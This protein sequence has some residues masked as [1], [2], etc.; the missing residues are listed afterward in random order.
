MRRT[1]VVATVV[2]LAASAA[3]LGFFWPFGERQSVLRLAGIVE[4]QEVR[5][6]SKVGGRVQEVLVVEGQIVSP[7]TSLVVFD[8]PE[9]EA[10]RDQL[11]AKLDAAVADWE[12]AKNGPRKEEI[13]AAQAAAEA[14]KARYERMLAGWR[15]E[16]K[17]QAKADL[18]SAEAEF[19][20]ALEDYERARELYRQRSTSRAEYDAAL[21]TR[22]RTR[23]RLTAVRAREEMLRVGNR[24]EDKAMAKAEWEQALWQSKLLQAGTRPEDKAAA[25]A[26]VDELRARLREVD[27]NLK[28][29]IVR[30]P[31]R[32]VVEVVAVRKGDLVAANQPVVRV[33]R[34]QDLWVKVYVPETEL[35]KVR[36]NQVVDVTVDAYPQ[37]RFKGRITQV[38][39]IAEFTPR[40]VQSV[41]ERRH[42]V[43]GV[44]VIV[45]N[46]QGVFKAGMAAEV[47]LPLQGAP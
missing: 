7:E 5:L 45:D 32:A 27:I 31:E 3:A 9:L 26:R 24:P 41:D 14:A 11:Q 39:S 34:A 47:Y 10:Q 23:G 16:E 46:P 25:K 35:G 22:D 8:E 38:A 13:E 12:K 44:K 15:E 17:Q 33:L 21:A 42:Q 1:V 29:R 30:A 19:R 28:E 37:K 40:N 43:F 6:G 4:I 18:A 36:L 2:L 20:Q